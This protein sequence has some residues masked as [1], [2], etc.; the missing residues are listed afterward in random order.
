MGL[1]C[2]SDDSE[3]VPP[4]DIVIS[5]SMQSRQGMADVNDGHS[6]EISHRQTPSARTATVTRSSDRL[7]FTPKTDGPERT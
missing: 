6:P 3:E 1:I 4:D 2:D 7:L 5:D